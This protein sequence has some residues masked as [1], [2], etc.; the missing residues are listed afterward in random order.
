M[1]APNYLLFFCLIGTYQLKSAAISKRNLLPKI[2]CTYH[3]NEFSY[4]FRMYLRSLRLFPMEEKITTSLQRGASPQ[5]LR[6]LVLPL[7]QVLSTAFMQEKM[8][9]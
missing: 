3:C 8:W 2:V 5:C 4:I 1:V 7:M 9:K 6:L